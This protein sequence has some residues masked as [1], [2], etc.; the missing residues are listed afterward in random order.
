MNLKKNYRYLLVLSLCLMALGVALRTLFDTEQDIFNDPIYKFLFNLP[1]GF[2]FFYV[3]IFAP[4]TEEIAFRS[5]AC[6]KRAWIWI[7]FAVSSIFVLLVNI[8]GGII[9]SVLFL[10][11]ILFLQAN[12]R[13]AIS[14]VIGAKITT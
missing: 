11:I 10:C 14:S 6:K 12:E 9:Y 4:I 5:W 13:K 1:L 8:Y 2:V 3:V 7:S